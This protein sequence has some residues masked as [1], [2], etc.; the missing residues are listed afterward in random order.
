MIAADRADIYIGEADTTG[1]ILKDLG[2]EDQFDRRELVDPGLTGHHIG[3]SRARP[4]ASQIA[5]RLDRAIEII[6]ADGRLARTIE[7]EKF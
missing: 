5:D 6:T 7:A 2:I 3:V 1:F 4:D